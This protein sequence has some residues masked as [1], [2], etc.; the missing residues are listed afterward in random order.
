MKNYKSFYIAMFLIT[1]FMAGMFYSKEFGICTFRFVAATIFTFFPI[2]LFA[3][4]LKELKK[5][6]AK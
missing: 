6:K 4:Y 3:L 2:I 5:W 1:F